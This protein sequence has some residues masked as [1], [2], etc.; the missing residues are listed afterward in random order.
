MSPAEPAEVRAR[1][2]GERRTGLQ[3]AEADRLGS[4]E[5]PY[6]S[7]SLLSCT[8][9]FSFLSIRF[10]TDPGERAGL[11]FRLDLLRAFRRRMQDQSHASPCQGVDKVVA[12]A[13]RE[14]E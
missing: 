4:E 13:K 7:P 2:A 1:A 6:Q 8:V 10:L 12:D 14:L 3:E 11:D 9:T 5:A